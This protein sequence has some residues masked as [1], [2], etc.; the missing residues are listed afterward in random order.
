MLG[1]VNRAVKRLFSNRNLFATNLA[2]SFSL[3][4]L[5]DWLQQ[6][7]ERTKHSSTTA[8]D[9]AAFKWNARRTLHMSTS[10]GLTSGFLC[11]YWYIFL[12]RSVVG[13]TG[14]SL[15][16]RKVVYDQ[17]IFSPV[18]IAACL[19]AAGVVEGSPSRAI[20]SDVVVKGGN[21]FFA[22]CLIWPPAQ[23]VNFYF[24]PTRYRVAFDNLVSLGF[25]TYTSHVKHRTTA[26]EE[27]L[28]GSEFPD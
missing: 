1:S 23:F 22:E 16:A 13:G 3:S 19:V 15:V 4:G 10:F 9:K 18:C 11:H 5:G 26:K 25:D 24:L 20:A 28:F 21:L 2:L 17:L 12:D 6:L 7:N 27:L 14:L 8:A